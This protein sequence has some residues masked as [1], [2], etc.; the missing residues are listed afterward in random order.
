MNKVVHNPNTKVKICGLSRVEDIQAA[1]ELK[2]DYIGFMLWPKSKRAVT[3]EQAA[4][5]KKQLAE[6]IKA[7]GVFVN[8]SAETIA[9][10][11]KSGVIEMVQLHGDE[12]LA[13]CKHLR[14][15]VDLPIIKAVRVRGEESFQGLDEYPVDYF[16]FD[17]Y[18]PGQYGGTGIRFNLKLGDDKR[19]SKP[20][21]VAG[22]LDACNVSEVLAET[23]AMAVDVSGGVETDGVKDYNKI[24][25]FIKSVRG[26]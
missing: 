2:P 9:K 23:Y 3:F 17:T 15:I 10:I 11:A 20:Y 14:E 22:G 26:E 16:L 25:A 5:L 7:V 1:N 8:E 21:F 19:I 18:V 6:G 12:D 13:Y 4:Q 24:A